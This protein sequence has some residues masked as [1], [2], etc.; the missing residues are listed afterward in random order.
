MVLLH[1][2]EIRAAYAVEGLDGCRRLLE[3]NRH[4]WRNIPLNVAVIGNSG[5]GKSSYINAIRGCLHV[6]REQQKS[7]FCKPPRNHAAFRIQTIRC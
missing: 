5:V 3:R 7:V 2:E 1:V 6:R 4:E